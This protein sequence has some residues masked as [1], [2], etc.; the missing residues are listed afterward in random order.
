MHEKTAVCIVCCGSVEGQHTTILGSPECPQEGQWLSLIL[1]DGWQ[2]K[3]PRTGRMF[4]TAQAIK[5]S[6][7]DSSVMGRGNGNTPYIKVV[8]YELGWEARRKV[9]WRGKGPGMGG[10]TWYNELELVFWWGMI[11]K[12]IFKQ[13][14][15]IIRFLCLRNFRGFILECTFKGLKCQSLETLRMTLWY[16]RQEMLRVYP[17]D[18]SR[19]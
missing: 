17:K 19:R 16:S 8:K 12:V 3:R 18:T 5:A 13:Q 1:T 7:P 11:L 4:Y 6:K 10:H 9:R 14:N 15:D 2:L